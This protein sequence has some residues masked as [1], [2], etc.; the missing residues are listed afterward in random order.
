MNSLNKDSIKF[1]IFT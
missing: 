1:C